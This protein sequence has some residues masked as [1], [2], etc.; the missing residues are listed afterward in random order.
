MDWTDIEAKLQERAEDVCRYLFPNGRREGGEWVVGSVAGEAGKSLKINLAGKVGLWRDFAGDHGGKSLLSLWMHARQLPNFGKAVQEAKQFL[1]I[2]DDYQQRVKSYSGPDRGAKPEESGWRAVAETW[3]KCAPLVA[4]G[5]VWKYLTEARRLDPAALEA[6]G[7]RE[8]ISNQRWIMVFPYFQAPPEEA[9]LVASGAPIP[10]WLKLEK[11]ERKD[12]RKEEWTS[13]APEKT[14][15]GLHLL[16]HPLFS[17]CRNVLICEGEKDA[18]TW[19]SYGC[20]E[21]GV[22]P[23]SVPFGAKWKGQDKNRP[24]PN[25]EWLDRS[26]HWLQNFETVFVSMDSDEAGRRAALDIISEI[27]PRRCR[28][29]VLP[30]QKKDANECLQTGVPRDEMKAALDTARDFAPEKVVAAADL[31]SEFLKYVFERDVEA[32]VTIPFDFPLRFRRKEVTLLMGLKGCGKSTLIDFLTVAA[33]AQGERALVASFEMPWEDTNDKLCRQAIGKHYFDRR[34]LK[35]CKSEEEHRM[36]LAEAR[37]QTVRAHRWLARR[38]WYYVH[39][40]I[41]HWKQLIDDMRWSRRR[42]GITWFVVDNFMRLGISKDDYAQQADAMIAFA[43]LAMEIDAHI[44]I[45][46]HQAKELARKARNDLY[47]NAAGASGAH[48]IA[49]NAHNILEVQRDD[50]KGKAVCELFDG[51]KLKTISE[52]DFTKKKAQLD[53]TPDGRFIMHNQRNGEHQD[54]AKAL[55]FLWESQQYVD[56]PEGHSDHRAICFVADETEQLS[57][58]PE[59]EEEL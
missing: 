13:K 8:F 35:D 32:G 23:V 44:I 53:L 11:L 34:R 54:G 57:Q 36:F 24:S 21:W 6:Y 40:G 55:W 50:R 42:L 14:L 7:V 29:V 25:R 43:S 10:E 1:G 2:S 47:G 51:R 37:E 58:P 17:G 31:E 16:A 56:V 20:S 18:I 49:D 3:G 39:V 26:W 45:V 12:G 48:E 15:F 41:A 19:A 33:M 59:W 5:P 38:L 52:E 46:I 4:G 30:Q 28:L 9:P 27:G 22:L